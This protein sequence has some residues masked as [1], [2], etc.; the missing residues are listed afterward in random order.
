LDFDFGMAFLIFG[1]MW[2]MGPIGLMGFKMRSILLNKSRV[3]QDGG[4]MDPPLLQWKLN[5]L[6]FLL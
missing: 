1:L 3:M 5:S 4:Y 6:E 2:P